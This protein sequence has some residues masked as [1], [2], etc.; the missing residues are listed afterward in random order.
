MLKQ[1]IITALLLAMAFLSALFYL[2]QALFALFIAT[3]VL[4]AAWEWSNLAGYG[5]RGQRALY[6][7]VTAIILWASAYYCDLGS[8]SGVNESHVRTLLLLGCGWW[9]VALLWVQGYP[10]SGLLWGGRFP[11]AIMGF[12]IL[13]PT[14]L[15]L[16]YLQTLEGGAWFILMSVLIC[17]LADIGGYFA[18]RKFGRN[19]LAPNVSPGKT[20]EGFWGGL[21]L[22]TL[23][24]LALSY[25]G[26][27]S[28]GLMLAVIIP[29]S[30]ASVLGDLVES[31]V[32]RHRRIKDSSRLLPGHGGVLDRVDS[33]T[34]AVPV[35]ALALLLSHWRL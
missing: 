31:M 20:W 5:R 25:F 13:M 17:A 2:P 27:Y 16:A 12:L 28:L 4:I 24:A 9:A 34:A 23:F 30:L 19:K 6:V 32:K 29:A 14:F 3:F 33:I 22:N 18:G 7:L 11:R 1:R 35:F 15:G 8:D 21:T 10:S 26:G